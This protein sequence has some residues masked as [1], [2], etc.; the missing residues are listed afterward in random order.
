MR[1]KAKVLCLATGGNDKLVELIKAKTDINVAPVNSEVSDAG[2][3]FLTINS[4][5]AEQCVVVLYMTPKLDFLELYTILTTCRAR[6]A[7][8]ICL[9]LPYLFY[10][11]RGDGES[12][13]K[14]DD[15][16][17]H[18]SSFLSTFVDTLITTS[19]DTSIRNQL[20][21][22]YKVPWRLVPLLNRVGDW[23]K[24][25][26]NSPLL[27]AGNT[28]STDIV[29]QL[30]R[31]YG[32]AF[33]EFS[34][35]LKAEEEEI[36]G[37]VKFTPIIVESESTFNRQTQHLV[38]TLLTQGFPPPVYLVGHAYFAKHT[39]EQILATGVAQIVTT[40]ALDHRSNDIDV[41]GVLAAAIEKQTQ[42]WANKVALCKPQQ[43]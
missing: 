10:K 43:Q 1:T 35:V 12:V 11:R 19:L 34:F 28:S 5:L 21:I 22:S 4:D 29:H 26:I 16:Q 40:N 15:M 42:Y 38:K 31:G 20:E 27:I 3:Y 6:Q 13:N 18:F 24:W 8:H 41:S 30:H 36:R 9:V 39:Y 25:N 32:F 17:Q 14:P 23:I 2:E 7:K 33:A 37:V